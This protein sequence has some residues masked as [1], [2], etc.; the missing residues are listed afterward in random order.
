MD[1]RVIAATNQ[2]LERAVASREGFGIPTQVVERLTRHRY[3]ENVRE[4]ENVVKRMIL[5]GPC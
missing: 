5:N 3:P 1:L 2:D 4:L